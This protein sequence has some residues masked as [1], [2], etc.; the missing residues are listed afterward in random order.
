MTARAGDHLMILFQCE[1]CHFSNIM[2][3]DPVCG[4]HNDTKLFEIMRRAN[5]D[6]FWEWASST[7]RSNNLGVGMSTKNT[8]VT[9]QWGLFV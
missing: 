8:T 7:V 3:F 5:L 9:H 6:G 1:L 4:E 2:G